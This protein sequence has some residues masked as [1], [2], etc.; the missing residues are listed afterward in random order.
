[1]FAVTFVGIFIAGESATGVD[2]HRQQLEA[3]KHISRHIWRG[4]A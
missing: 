4:H 3:D 1:M 2:V